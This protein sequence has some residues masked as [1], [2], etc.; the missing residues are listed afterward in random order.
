M[1]CLAQPEDAPW[2]VLQPTLLDT[3]CLSS[4]GALCPLL[5]ITDFDDHFLNINA[6][7]PRVSSYSMLI[8][9]LSHELRKL[10]KNP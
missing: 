9:G 10:C 3:L 1:A 5:V 8:L 7:E 6:P 2:V 4:A